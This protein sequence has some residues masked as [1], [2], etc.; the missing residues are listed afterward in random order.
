MKPIT[1][2][3]ASLITNNSTKLNI[4]ISIDRPRAI[5]LTLYSNRSI[6]L[7]RSI[8]KIST[9]YPAIFKFVN[10]YHVV[11]LDGVVED[12]AQ[13][14]YEYDIDHRLPLINNTNVMK[15]IY[16]EVTGASDGVG[17]FI[18]TVAAGQDP[19]SVC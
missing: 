18:T 8:Y 6:Q 5:S 7:S 15:M 9:L 11:Q 10:K 3:T 17:L 2:A 16:L 1:K 19:R 12:L 14:Q 13:M 4:Q